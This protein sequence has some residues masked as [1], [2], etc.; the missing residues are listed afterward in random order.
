[1]PVFILST[2]C[3]GADG[4]TAAYRTTV[5]QQKIR[6]AGASEHSDAASVTQLY[7]AWSTSLNATGGDQA[8]QSSGT[9]RP[10]H[11]DD[12][13]HD[14][15]KNKQFDRYSDSGAF[16]PWTLWKGSLG[17]ELFNWNHSGNGE[18]MRFRTSAKSDRPYPP[19]VCELACIFIIIFG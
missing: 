3:F 15:E 2:L 9:P 19:W 4:A 11:L 18:Q 6:A 8:P 16:P 14:S 7:N 13:R 5:L 17:L 10:P 12:C 1:M